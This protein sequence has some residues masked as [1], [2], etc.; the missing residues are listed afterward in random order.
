MGN[1]NMKNLKRKRFEVHNEEAE[2]MQDLRT[3]GEVSSDEDRE[4]EEGMPDLIAAGES[5]DDDSDDDSDAP[6]RTTPSPTQ[7]L[8]MSIQ[9]PTLFATLA[10]PAHR[11]PSPTAHRYPLLVVLG[12]YGQISPHNGSLPHAPTPTPQPAAARLE[13]HTRG[14][15]HLHSLI[16][17]SPHVQ[18]TIVNSTN[19]AI[20]ISHYLT[21]YANK[22]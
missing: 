17:I 8:T 21:M 20:S 6:I 4:E 22:Q 3:A 14:S 9:A 2:G 1:R 11:Q 10:H 18:P 7:Y 15:L 12:D 16:L 5:S 13:Y 19:S